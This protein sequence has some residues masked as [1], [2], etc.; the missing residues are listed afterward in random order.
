MKEALEVVYRSIEK[1][2]TLAQSMASFPNVFSDLFISFVRVGESTGRLQESLELLAEQ[3]KKEFELKRAVRGGLL[4]P[5]VILTALVAVGFAMMV[6]VI[7]KLI[8][9]FEGFEVELPLMTRILIRI[10]GFFEH[11]WYIVLLG[12][13]GAV[14]GTYFLMR[15]KSVKSTVMHGFLY[16]PIIGGIMQQVNLA[17]F[18]RNLSSLLSSGVSFI[19]SL[20]ILGSNTPHPSYARVFQAA[21]DHVKQG[22]QLSDFLV[23]FQR[24]F[25]PLV[26]NVIKVG[27]ET[28]Q[29]DVVLKEIALFYESEVDQTMKNLT[30]IMEPVLMVII[31]I[32]V[33]A[34]AVSVLSPI[35]SLVNVI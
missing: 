21:E 17:R 5:A 35:Y 9:V 26:I 16:M 28:G 13:V 31:G 11:Y 32:A 8:E 29:I 25:P 34:L 2:Q 14:V 15:V 10:S 12:M 22:K 19:E 4:Y 18:A 7:P 33:G 27:E 3:L 30:S 24:M 6:F 1:G 20:R 23:E